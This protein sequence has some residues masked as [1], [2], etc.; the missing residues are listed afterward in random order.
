[1][2]TSLIKISFL[3]AILTCSIEHSFGADNN[4]TSGLKPLEVVE[5]FTPIEGYP[6]LDINPTLI[7]NSALRVDIVK[8]YGA[9]ADGVND[10]SSALQKAIN[11]VS[12]KPNGGIVYMPL[13]EYR[14]KE[15][16]M[17]SNVHLHIEAGSVITMP[18]SEKNTNLFLLGEKQFIENVVIRGVNGRFKIDLVGMSG[19]PRTFR[20]KSVHNFMICDIDI[21]DYKIPFPIIG[22]GP[23]ANKNPDIF[24]PTNGVIRN[25]STDDSHYGYGLIQVQCA[26]KVLFENLHGVG[27]V[28]LRF[29]TGEKKMNTSQFGGVFDCR[30]QNISGKNGNATVMIS[31]HAMKDGVVQVDGIKCES[32]GVGVRIDNGYEFVANKGTANEIVME[33]GTYSKGSY[34]ANVSCTFGRTAQVKTKHIPYMPEELL[35]EV[36]EPYFKTICQPSPSVCAVL[37]VP[38]YPIDIL[39]EVEAIGYI[40]E[41]V[42]KEP[43]A[44]TKSQPKKNKK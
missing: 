1:M 5:P 4:K 39:G 24:G 34:I 31:P 16:T 30:G 9:V 20:L 29:E 15:I 3:A 10:D 13:G 25:C 8:D 37:F 19:S 18:P 7:E 14:L 33:P 28:V 11:F 23:D 44:R 41:A 32:M 12:S 17:K 36:P 38:N 22:L 27:G 21:S 43:A 40:N 35:S 6:T 42:V 26:K 2:K